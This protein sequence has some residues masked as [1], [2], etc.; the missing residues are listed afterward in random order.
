MARARWWAPSASR[1]TP[2]T[3]T[4]SPA[5]RPSASRAIPGPESAARGYTDAG[6]AGGRDGALGPGARADGALVRARGAAAPRPAL[7]AAG[8]LRGAPDG[9]ARAAARP[10]RQV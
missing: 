9:A 7:P 3:T 6:A 10:A 8:A 5:S 2:P 1:A 4:G